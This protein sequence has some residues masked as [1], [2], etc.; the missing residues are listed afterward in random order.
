MRLLA[1]ATLVSVVLLSSQTLANDEC[2]KA[3]PIT[4]D[5]LQCLNNTHKKAN[6]KLNEQYSTMIANFSQSNKKMLVEGE[7]AWTKYRD[8]RCNY[9]YESVLPGEEA[10]I[11][12]LACLNSLTSSRLVEL[13]YLDTGAIADSFYSS[14]SVINRISSKS[15]EEILIHIESLEDHPGE[16]EY[17]KKNCELTAIM[18]AE[19]ERLCRTR[20]RF[21]SM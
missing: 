19:D 2:D 15:R 14:L 4:R 1:V 3:S 11:E 7:R 8:S 12:K 13:L 18:H 21:Q 10:E 6:K 20:M 17:Y 9:I 16:L 5:I